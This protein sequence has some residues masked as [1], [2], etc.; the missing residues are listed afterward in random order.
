M[1]LLPV[2][3]GFFGGHVWTRAI[4]DDIGIQLIAKHYSQDDIKNNN[5]KVFSSYRETKFSDGQVLP[6]KEHQLHRSEVFRRTL[7]P[8]ILFFLRFF[9]CV[10][11]SM[12]DKTNQEQ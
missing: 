2:A 7:P 5:I 1:I 3:I 11:S 12:E 4:V 8:D 6:E 9:S 10:Y